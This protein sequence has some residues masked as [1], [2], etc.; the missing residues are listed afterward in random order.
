MLKDG[1]LIAN[2]GHHEREVAIDG[3]GPG[4]E[5]RPGV[6]EHDLGGGRRAYVLAEGRQTNVAGGDGHPVEIMDLSFSVQALA[7]HL[8]A[9]AAS[10]PACT[11]SRTSSTGRSRARSSRRSGS[12][13]ASRRLSSASSRPAGRS[14]YSR[15]HWSSLLP[16]TRFPPPV[17]RGRFDLHWRLPS[18]TFLETTE[19]PCCVKSWMS[20]STVLR[21]RLIGPTRA[22]LQL[23]APADAA[24]GDDDALRVLGL[25]VA[26]DTDAGR[27]ERR[28]A[29]DLH[30]PVDAGA[31]EPAGRAARDADVDVQAARADRA[32]AVR[33]SFVAA[34][35]AAA[36]AEDAG[37]ARAKVDRPSVASLTFLIVF[38]SR[39]S[40]QVSRRLAARDL[41][42]ELG[43][44]G[45]RRADADA[46]R[47][48][49]V[50]LALR[51]AGRAGDDRAGV[52][53]R[54]ARAAR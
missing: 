53:H 22:L 39:S 5:V 12:S 38:P 21:V 25:D 8:L 1:V 42:D 17:G 28:V 14:S 48:E 13:S 2:G 20:E 15:A 47:L 54:L 11:A 10:S 49:R 32:A 41:G 24:A 45:R 33:S 37:A 16:S 30:V 4:E 18:T 36:S 52:A 23:D 3:L 27:D 7:V 40:G 26:A 31:L 46:L 29:V 19:L 43:G 44:L 34:G 50:L 51:G 35:A 6:T 9:A